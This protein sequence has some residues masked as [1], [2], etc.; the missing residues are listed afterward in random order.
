MLRL[1]LSLGR[2][3]FI[4]MVLCWSAPFAHE[5]QAAG[6]PG[7]EVVLSREVWSVLRTSCPRRLAAIDSSNG[8]R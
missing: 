3:V 4:G 8:T 7:K 2:A 6:T 5:L 1:R